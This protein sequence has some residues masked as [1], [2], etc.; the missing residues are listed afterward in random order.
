MTIYVEGF[1]GKQAF[2]LV[3]EV[4]NMLIDA[5]SNGKGIVS[6]FKVAI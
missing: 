6:S 2:K 3:K 4:W 1:I 5:E